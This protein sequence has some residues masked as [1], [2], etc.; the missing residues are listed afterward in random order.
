[1]SKTIEVQTA[2]LN[3]PAMCVVC[4]SPSTKLYEVSQVYSRGTKSA[5]VQIHVPMCTSHF[6]A[7]TSKSLV[8]KIIAILA[9]I[10][11]ICS[12]LAALAI[13]VTRWVGDDSLILKLI[14]GSIVGFGVFVMAWAL[15]AL[16]VAPMFASTES[17][18]ARNAVRIV[19]VSPHAEVLR[20]EFQNEQLAEIVQKQNSFS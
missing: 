8:E 3:F 6:E 14:I 9:I 11:G 17:K 10:L 5:T 16:W 18:E 4:M 15:I 1:M 2:N 7:A 19:L 13:L 12:G 20:L